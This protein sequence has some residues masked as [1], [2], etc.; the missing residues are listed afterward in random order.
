MSRIGKEVVALVLVLALAG[1]VVVLLLRLTPT[2]VPSLYDTFQA[3]INT[4]PLQ[5]MSPTEGQV[6]TMP[7]GEGSSVVEGQVLLT[8]Q[9]FDRNYR[10]P[11]DS[12]MFKLQGD[13]LQIVSPASGIVGR[14][15][16]APM[17]TVAGNQLLLQVLTPQ[18]TDL[19]VLIPQN[20]VLSHYRD[21]YAATNSNAPWYPIQILTT[22]PNEIVGGVAP[23]ITVYRATCQTVA[24]CQN[25]LTVKQVE[26]F[27]KIIH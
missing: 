1:G 18:S 3:R 9:V 23:A 26:V 14:M 25:F 5:I 20:S 7:S 8:V 11:A 17:S 2:S 16:V 24:D 13:R 19:Q 27:A 6:L 21:F 22:I 4:I 12:Q 15:Q 10:P